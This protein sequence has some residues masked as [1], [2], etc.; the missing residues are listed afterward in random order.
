MALNINI[1]GF[2]FMD[3]VKGALNMYAKI[4]SHHFF[5]I[6]MIRTNYK[7]RQT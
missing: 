5:L 7:T 4:S 6:C 2:L 3:I 1:S